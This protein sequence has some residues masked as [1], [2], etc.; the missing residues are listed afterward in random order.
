MRKLA[1]TAFGRARKTIS[2]NGDGTFSIEN[3]NPRKTLKWTFKLG[4]Q[5]EAE[6]MDDKKHKVSKSAHALL[7]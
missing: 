2:D 3:T 4:E 5:F 7:H 1:M 6:A